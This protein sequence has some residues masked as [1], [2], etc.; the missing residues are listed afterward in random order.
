MFQKKVEILIVLI[1]FIFT[2]GCAPSSESLEATIASNV[3]ATI[4]AIPTQTPLSTL[5]PFPTL[6]PQATQTPYPTM[7]PA[8]TFTPYPTPEPLLADISNL[9][10]DFGFCIRYLPDTLEVPG[11]A[12]D[13][14]LQIVEDLNVADDGVL[15]WTDEEIGLMLLVWEDIDKKP[16]E[17]I[18]GFLDNEEFSNQG[19]LQEEKIGEMLVTHASFEKA[20]EDKPYRLIAAWRCDRR[21]FKLQLAH[22]QIEQP[23]D[24]L[25]ASV[26]DFVCSS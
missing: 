15:F 16:S 3:A 7:T 13:V 20:G 12:S 5:T 2:T 8:P 9:Y 14:L 25:H 18:V 1:V 23:M 11:Y 17:F 19:E 22:H 6:T 26:T 4:E 24:M 10:C 21:L